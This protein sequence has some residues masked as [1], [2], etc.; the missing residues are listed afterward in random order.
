MAHNILNRYLISQTAVFD[1]N[2]PHITDPSFS[3][4]IH[5]IRVSIKKIRTLFLLLEFIFPEE[6]DA[7]AVYRPFKKLF[8]QLGGIRDLQV[9][10]KLVDHYTGTTKVNIEP[11]RIFLKARYSAAI[12]SLPRWLYQYQKPHQGQIF[13]LIRAYYFKTGRETIYL[14]AREYIHS[15]INQV[16]GLTEHK[17]K[18]TIHRIRRLLK[19]ARY[20]IDMLGTVS[21]NT[22]LFKP[23][24][25][26]IKSIENF[27]GDWHDRMISLD[28][29]YLFEKQQMTYPTSHRI[30]MQPVIKRILQENSTL[31]NKS[32]R[33]IKKLKNISVT[34]APISH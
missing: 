27:L 34:N 31:V 14:K 21:K 8:K 5:D 10:I 24:Q 23:L 28:H 16:M 6:F 7:P 20:M 22:V 26:Q 30:N 19:E 9:Q 17:D 12:H 33:Q 3:E 4:A 32:M 25:N 29:I 2:Y 15:K 1:K 18:E 11:Y 13:A